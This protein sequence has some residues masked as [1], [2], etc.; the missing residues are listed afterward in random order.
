MTGPYSY[1]F[2]S[3]SNQKI[4]N[5]LF[6]MASKTLNYDIDMSE[7]SLLNMKIAKRTVFHSRVL[8]ELPTEWKKVGKIIN[9]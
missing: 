5:S 9:F 3:L 1:A 7:T 8:T 4:V 2:Y 6:S